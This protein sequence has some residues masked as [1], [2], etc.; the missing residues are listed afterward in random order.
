MILSFVAARP[1]PW[2]DR[3]TALPTQAA[4]AGGSLDPKQHLNLCMYGYNVSYCLIHL[5]ARQSRKKSK[6]E[7][8]MRND[9]MIASVAILHFGLIQWT[10]FEGGCH[11]ETDSSESRPSR[12]AS[13]IGKIRQEKR[14]KFWLV[15]RIVPIE[16]RILHA[17]PLF[18]RCCV[19]K[20]N[21]EF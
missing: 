20:L 7:T 6:I 8:L 14:Y 2:V 10:S 18:T 21:V 16:M 13:E 12:R 3:R 11:F 15:M 5:F 17:R 19:E 9:L 1:R 4:G